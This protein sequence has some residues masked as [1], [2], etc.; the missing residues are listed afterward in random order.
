MMKLVAASR[1]LHPYTTL[2][3]DLLDQVHTSHGAR[4]MRPLLVYLV[5]T[6]GTT[7]DMD[8]I[9]QSLTAKTRTTTMTLL[10]QLEARGEARGFARGGAT[11][12]LKQLRVRFGPLPAALVE[13]VRSAEVSSLERWAVRVFHA[14][15]LDEIFATE[16]PWSG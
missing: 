5:G 8:T 6:K 11:L 9:M 2:V 4:A 7:E 14:D 16:D 12:L 1:T 10:E 3:A 15:D 13:R